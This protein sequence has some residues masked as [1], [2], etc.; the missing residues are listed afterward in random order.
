MNAGALISTKGAWLRRI[1]S[2]STRR[3]SR[4]QTVTGELRGVQ[5]HGFGISPHNLR[6]GDC[7]SKKMKCVLPTG[8]ESGLSRTWLSFQKTGFLHDGEFFFP[9][10]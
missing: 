4:P 3:K 1:G 8:I 2:R 9:S 6:N 5:A 10:L 7:A